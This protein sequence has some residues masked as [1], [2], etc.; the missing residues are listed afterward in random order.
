M[1]PSYIVASFGVI[2]YALF[3][4]AHYY[5]GFPRLEAV[6]SSTFWYLA[7]VILP[8]IIYFFLK[9]EQE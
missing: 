9:K 8:L 7:G 2:L 1:N 3:T 5:T 4:I 6:G